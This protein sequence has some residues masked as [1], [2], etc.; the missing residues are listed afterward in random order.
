MWGSVLCVT[1]YNSEKLT[2]SR[3]HNYT[4]LHKKIH[5][6][7]EVDFFRAMQKKKACLLPGICCTCLSVVSYCIRLYKAQGTIRSKKT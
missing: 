6:K 1:V 5:V 4:N 2:R 7:K 3:T